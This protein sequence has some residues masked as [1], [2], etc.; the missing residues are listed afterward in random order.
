[1]TF[2]VSRSSDDFCYKNLDWFRG[3]KSSAYRKARSALTLKPSGKLDL[4][5]GSSECK[6][7]MRSSERYENDKFDLVLVVYLK[8]IITG[9]V[10]I[11]DGCIYE[12][13]AIFKQVF[14]ML[15]PKKCLS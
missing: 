1:M 7:R 15:N 11:P 10:I 5:I 2:H 3:L 12:K 13:V 4:G 14:R 9:S 6:L 8:Y